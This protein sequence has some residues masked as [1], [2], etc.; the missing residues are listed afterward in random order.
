MWEDQEAF[1][2]RLVLQI[3][4]TTHFTHPHPFPGHI[5]YPESQP[6]KGDWSSASCPYSREPSRQL[7][8]KHKA[9]KRM[10]PLA[11]ACLGGAALNWGES[12]ATRLVVITIQTRKRSK[13][14]CYQPS[15]NYYVQLKAMD[16]LVPEWQ[17]RDGPDPSHLRV[18]SVTQV[19]SL[20][21][22]AALHAALGLKVTPGSVRCFEDSLQ[23][24]A[25]ASLLALVQLWPGVSPSPA[26]GPFSL[27]YKMRGLLYTGA[28]I[29]V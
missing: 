3:L 11:P 7:R 5:N 13:P 23:Q 15:A 14:S 4:T 24:M 25:W 10:P 26:W 29:S 21:I 17:E 9:A 6:Q 12:G 20:N 18:G 1:S 28:S 22:S 16:L 27:I 19:S 8:W 2:H